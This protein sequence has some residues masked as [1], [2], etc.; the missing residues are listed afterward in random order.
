MTDTDKTIIQGV[1]STTGQASLLYYSSDS[2]SNAAQTWNA[3]CPSDGSPAQQ[4]T[5]ELNVIGGGSITM[6]AYLTGFSMTCA[7]GEVVSADI[8]WEAT[9]TPAPFTF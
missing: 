6:E 3:L 5:I 1:R 8:T 7:V 4:V 9:G 2:T